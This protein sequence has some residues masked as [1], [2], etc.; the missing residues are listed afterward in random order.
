MFDGVGTLKILNEQYYTGDFKKGKVDGNGK[1]IFRNG[2]KISEE[3]SGFWK[4]GKIQ[5]T[6]W[7]Y[8]GDQAFILFFV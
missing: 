2:N 5:L 6:L 3:V 4:E 7:D 1:F 8:D